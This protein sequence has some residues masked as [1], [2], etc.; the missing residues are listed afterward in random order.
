MKKEKMVHL[1]LLLATVILHP[2]LYGQ[3]F[4]TMSHAYG[5]FEEIHVWN[6]VFFSYFWLE[7]VFVLPLTLA[8]VALKYR[9]VLLNNHLR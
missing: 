2:L 1:K 7:F 9:F 8:C 3:N 5:T 6:L 4:I